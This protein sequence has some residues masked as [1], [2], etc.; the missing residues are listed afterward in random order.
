MPKFLDTRG[1]SNLAIAVCDRCKMKK[2]L[3]NLR[4]D[5]NFPGLRVCGDGCADQFD[6]YRL[7]ARQTERINLRF[8]RP[9]VSVA[10]YNN[11]ITTG[12]YGEFVLSP[13][14]NTQTPE[15]NGNLD[16]IVISPDTE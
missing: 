5:P 14:Q 15:N 11:A 10:V 4:P 16:S 12:E 1:L 8:P 2:P 6:P 7:P 9:D 13:E 3:V